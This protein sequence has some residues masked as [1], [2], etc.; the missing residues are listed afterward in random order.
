[1]RVRTDLITVLGRALGDSFLQGVATFMVVFVTGWYG[2]SQESAYAGILGVGVGAIVG[3]LI[4]GRTSDALLGRGWLHGRVLVGAL[5]NFAGAVAFFAAVSTR[6]FAVAVPLFAAGPSS[7]PAPNR[8]SMP[9]G[10]TCSWGNSG[11][12]PRPSSRW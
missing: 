4:L 8:S 2:L 6:S 12:A 7:S 9:S 1:V 10:W 11:A 3:V 5:A